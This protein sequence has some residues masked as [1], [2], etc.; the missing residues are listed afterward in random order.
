MNRLS[1]TIVRVLDVAVIAIIIGAITVATI[2]VA[3][4]V[5]AQS[6]GAKSSITLPVGFAPS[7]VA[8]LGSRTLGQGSIGTMNGSLSFPAAPATALTLQLAFLLIVVVPLLL[9]L[10]LLRGVFASV[11]N[12]EPFA[13]DVARKVRWLGLGVVALYASKAIAGIMVWAFLSRDLTSGPLPLHP[14]GIDPLGL[15]VGF[16]IIA[17][18]EAFRHGSKLRAD[19]D[20]TV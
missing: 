4:L 16:A 8:Q 12:G 11:D 10:R 14:S 6:L 15:F 1:H 9:F 13:D 17:L 18:A 19:A 5:P 7:T 2:E 3:V 20:L